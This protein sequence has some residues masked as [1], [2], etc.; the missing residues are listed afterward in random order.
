MSDNP[1]SANAMEHL[2]LA[3]YYN[4]AEMMKEGK[5]SEEIVGWLIEKG[6]KPDTAHQMMEKLGVSRI[7]V[8]R[9]YGRRNLIAGMLICGIGLALAT[10]TL[11]LQ[12]GDEIR[13]L[14]GLALL[15]GGYLLL[16]AVMQLTMQ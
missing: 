16:R 7:N 8:I 14:A 5:S 9:R 6:V 12:V 13:L 15:P 2:A 10:G 11:N 4:A 3:L 1:D